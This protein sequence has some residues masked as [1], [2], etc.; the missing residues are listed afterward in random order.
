MPHE[1]SVPPEASTASTG[2]GI[3]YIGK[4]CYAYSGLVG[5]T[6]VETDLLNTTTGAGYILCNIQ[7]NYVTDSGNNFNYK[8]YLNDI[9]V[10]AYFLTSAEAYTEPDNLIPLLIPPQSTLRCTAQNASTSAE[11]EIITSLTGRVYGA[12]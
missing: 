12:E 11:I 3:R 10:Q 6:N 5:C 8:V 2:L 4:H 9:V 7:F 1:A